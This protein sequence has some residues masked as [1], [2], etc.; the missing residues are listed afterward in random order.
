MLSHIPCKAVLVLFSAFGLAACGGGGG[1]SGDDSPEPSSALSLDNKGYSTRKAALN[2]QAEYE[3]T[4]TAYESTNAVAELVNDV[5]DEV[6]DLIG[7]AEH[8]ET[9]AAD[10]VSALAY[11]DS[12]DLA[13]ENDGGSLRIT[14]KSSGNMLELRYA[15]TD[16]KL[17]TANEGPLLLRG[18]YTYKRNESTEGPIESANG[19][20]AYDLSG[21]V[22]VSDTPFV[23]RGGNSWTE[24]VNAD[25]MQAN[26][27]LRTDVMEFLKGSD[28]VALENYRS[29]TNVEENLV[30]SSAEFRLTSSALNG[31]V[32]YTTPTP[33]VV[34]LALDGCPLQGIIR[35]DGDGVVEVR[36][37]RD[38]G[39]SFDIVVEINNNAVASYETCDALDVEVYKG[40]PETE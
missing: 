13:C 4:M 2:Q 6:I 28:Y 15:F 35:I 7:E 17:T 29:T 20:E 8:S 9:L 5:I 31:Y 19:S 37:G 40:L 25:A 14:D 1:S 18:S 27:T 22:L 12:L 10:D 11:N 30:S 16:C 32:D 24:Y 3:R 36:Y 34:D 26:F 39:T 21:T 33:V 23:L 38:T